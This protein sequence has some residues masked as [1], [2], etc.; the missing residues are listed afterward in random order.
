MVDGAQRH[1]LLNYITDK[2]YI[3]NMVV[4]DNRAK[5]QSPASTSVVSGACLHH[6]LCPASIHGIASSGCACQR[7]RQLPNLSAHHLVCHRWKPWLHWW[8]TTCLD[9]ISWWPHVFGCFRYHS[10]AAVF[11]PCFQFTIDALVSAWYPLKAEF[12]SY[13]FPNI[14]AS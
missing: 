9:T 2:L 14:A 3:N 6:A 13:E 12:C 4:D 5:K 7:Q 1:A 10:T 8:Q 11:E